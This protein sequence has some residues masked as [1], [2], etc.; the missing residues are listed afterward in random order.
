M[1]NYK[2]IGFDKIIVSCYNE[3]LTEVFMKTLSLFVSLGLL[4][5]TAAQAMLPPLYTSLNEYKVLLASPQL[6]KAL[7]SGEWIEKIEHSQGSFLIETNKHTL[8]VDV[9]RDTQDVMGPE[10]FHFV[11]HEAVP[12]TES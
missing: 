9:V 5:T 4:S 11:F 3:G 6:T 12:K 7:D 10:R 8:E 1:F 2:N